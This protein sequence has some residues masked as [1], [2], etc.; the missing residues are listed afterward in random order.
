MLSVNGQKLTSIGQKSTMEFLRDTYSVTTNSRV[1]ERGTFKLDLKTKPTG[2]DMSI[3][4]GVA[5]GRTQIGLVQI[6]GDELTLKTNTVGRPL[7]PT[8]FKNETWYA[9]IVATK[10]K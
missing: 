8:D 4:E 10:Q 5:A 1:V 3:V 6:L 2:I 7:R 9:L